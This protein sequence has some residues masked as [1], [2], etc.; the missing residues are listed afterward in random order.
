MASTESVD[1]L[2]KAKTGLRRVETVDKTK[3]NPN[4]GRVIGS[5][6]SRN[7]STNQAG[8]RKGQLETAAGDYAGGENVI[9]RKSTDDLGVQSGT[10][11]ESGSSV[12]SISSHTA[13][14]KDLTAADL[15]VDTISTTDLKQ[16]LN[17]LKNDLNILVTKL[18]L[19]KERIRQHELKKNQ[20]LA[21]QRDAGI[22]AEELKSLGIKK[23]EEKARSL[24]EEFQYEVKRAEAHRRA[25][26]LAV[27]RARIRA[28]E[29]LTER[30]QRIALER[31]QC[32]DHGIS[33]GKVLKGRYER[34]I[35]ILK[36]QQELLQYEL[37]NAKILSKKPHTYHKA[38]ELRYEIE[39][40]E[41]EQKRIHD[42]IKLEKGFSEAKFEEEL[43]DL[44]FTSSSL[45]Y[46]DTEEYRE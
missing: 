36:L 14:N 16:Q 17:I 13:D 20:N 27:E 6:D 23:E 9:D 40:E 29:I 15:G 42:D 1:F 46:D 10:V 37:E 12:E 24:E 34:Q 22:K 2:N 25:S 45:G 28:S 5:E 32:H 38:V 7:L 43:I 39:P 4:L 18:K 33:F 19:S 8:N 44:G 31:S 26:E 35:K 41:L 21:I 3:D 11:T 30:M